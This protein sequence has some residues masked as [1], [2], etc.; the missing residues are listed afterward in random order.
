M[1]HASLI[2]AVLLVL[3]ASCGWG[4]VTATETTA[5]GAP[6]VVLAN[7]YLELTLAPTVGGRIADILFKPTGKRLVGKDRG[8]F[9]DRVWNYADREIY[10]QWQDGVY[11]YEVT[12]RPDE[13]A[14]KLSCRGKVGVSNRMAFVKTITLREGS[15][16]IR[17]DYEMRIGQE[18]MVPQRV[19]LWWHN[20]PTVQGENVSYFLPVESG[21]QRIDYGAG[22]KGEYWWYEPARGWLGCVGESGAGLAVVMEYKRLMCFYQW[23]SGDAPGLEFAFRSEEIANGNSLKTTIWLLPFAEM[24][25]VH[26][27]GGGV[28]VSLETE[29]EGQTVSAQAR[30]A[31][32]VATDA[33]VKVWWRKLEDDDKQALGEK[34]LRLAPAK[35]ASAPFSFTAPGEGTFVVGG[36]VEAGGKTLCDFERPVVIGKPSGKYALKPVEE[37]TGR[38]DERF[39]DKIAATG[40]GP[41]DITLSMDIETPHVKW[42]KPYVKGKTK[43][44]I[45]QSALAGRE[46]IELAQRMDLDYIAPTIDTPYAIGYTRG[47]LAKPM[48][49]AHALENVKQALKQDLDVILIGGFK[50]EM[51]SDEVIDAIIAKVKGGTGLVWA[52]PNNCPERLWEILPLGGWKPTSTS[53]QKWELAADHYIT[54]GLPWRALPVTGCSYYEP[55]GEALVKTRRGTLIAVGTAGKGRV[56]GLGYNTSWQGPGSYSNG[57]TPWVQR[58]EAKFAYWEYHHSLLAKALL[59]AANKESDVTIESIA[60]AQEMYNR[61]T[62]A[63]VELKLFNDAADAL[64]NISASFQ[65]EYGHS[66]GAWRQDLVVANGESAVQIPLPNPLK[67]GLHLVDVIVKREGA[68]VNWGSTSLVVE[69]PAAIE[70]VQCDKEIYDAQ[71]TCAAQIGLRIPENQA[72]KYTLKWSLTDGLG[73]LI[74]RASHPARAG[75]TE[76]KLPIPEPL[77]TMAMLR[78]ELTEGDAVVSARE[79]QIVLMPTSWAKRQWDPREEV[80]WG[81]PVGAYSRDYLHDAATKQLKSLGI[82]ACLTGAN[83]LHD[84]EQK[85]TFEAGFKLM[86]VGVCGSILRL[87]RVRKPKLNYHEQHEQYIK[88]RDKKFLERPAC[89]T[90][91]EDRA[92]EKELMKKVCEAVAKFKPIGYCCGDELGTTHYTTPF[93][94]DFSPEGLEDFREWLRGEYGTLDALNAE[95]ETEF[96]TWDEVMPMTTLEVKGRGNYAPWADH[97]EFMEW[98][99]ADFYKFAY[100][101]VNEFDPGALIG[102]SGTQAAEAYGG[103][104]WWRLAHALDFIQAYDHKNT[105]EMHRSFGVKPSVPWWGYASTGPGL[106]HTL[107][108]RLFNDVDGGSFFVQTYVLKPDYTFTQS[109]A[110]GKRFLADIRSGIGR[111][112]DSCDERA[113]DV[114]IHYSHPSIHGA[115]I[116]GHDHLFRDNRDGWVQ[117]IYDLGLQFDFIAYAEIEQG[118]LAKRKPKALILPYSI[119]LSADEVEAI[120]AYVRDGGCVIADGRVGLMDDH[121]RTLK[122]GAL[123]DL[124]GVARAAVDPLAKRREGD[125]TFP[126]SLDEKETQPIVIDGYAAEAELKLAGG[127]ALGSVGD[128]PL[129]IINELGKGSAMLL[130]MFVDQYPRRVQL[131]VAGNMRRLI[132]NVLQK[133]GVAPEFI[134]TTDEAHRV[135]TVRY[136]SGA[137]TYLGVLRN[138]SEG[139]SEVSVQWSRPSH[140]YDVRAGKHLGRVKQIE[141]LTPPGR[142]ELYALLPYTVKRVK[143]DVSGVAKPG[144]EVKCH[145][146]VQPTGGRAGMHVLRVEVRGP[147]GELREHYGKQITCPEGSDEVSFELALNDPTGKWTVTATDVGTG[148]RGSAEFEVE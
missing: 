131:N 17:A 23:L 88:T 57:I 9:Q 66:E 136:L 19:G 119:A 38:A 30:V 104:D 59:W 61:G 139:Q 132:R 92:G 109:T 108:R 8:I 31:G 12:R 148:V 42:A 107:W 13:V 76:I 129:L 72:E 35:T 97:R 79:E 11:E 87:S 133:A 20:R 123:D 7:E 143:V 46:T 115:Y 116:A 6:V 122:Q 126:G 84:G 102:I 22:A 18:A 125:L 64:L 105:G 81:T 47:F 111:L 117:A 52:Q 5:D 24:P 112:L 99:F 144:G 67:A 55:R 77:C 120:K 93:D 94:Y 41:K 32:S 130:N 90:G 27:A 53:P 80:I 106:E 134:V 127:K 110:D 145:L 98:S 1:R 58:S 96:K 21:V 83:W 138:A 16:A 48:T 68:V 91:E 25:S 14:V 147:D 78:C 75:D 28:A 51:F 2:C 141:R 95:W 45:L 124:F 43:A 3:A 86:P 89:L 71:D 36:T 50:G 39:G 15:S 74:A 65:D 73:R 70:S 4:A 137:A 85:A 118:E 10:N 60:P 135:L 49:L 128:A 26:G 113:A 34:S 54:V 142:A 44:L 146:A 101:C 37:R 69:S 56:V 82:T 33:I 63:V 29:T 121:C 103:Y 140:V 40:T 62:Q 100:N 114:L